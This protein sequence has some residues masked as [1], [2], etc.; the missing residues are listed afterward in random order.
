M[1]FGEE[2][3]RKSWRICV[4]KYDSIFYIIII[5]IRVGSSFTPYATN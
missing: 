1:S 3:K 5:I 4:S 2:I